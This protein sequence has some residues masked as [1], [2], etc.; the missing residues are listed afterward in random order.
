MTTIG[1]AGD[2]AAYFR[3]QLAALRPA[4]PVGP[5]DRATQTQAARRGPAP[6][7]SPGGKASAA[8]SEDLASV[9]ARRVA[10]IDRQDPDRRRK[11]FRVFLEALML[12]EWGPQLINDPGF[13][14]VVDSVHQQMEAQPGLLLLMDE[15]ARRLLEAPGVPR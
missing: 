8:G 10:A 4:Q 15:A 6:G 7:Q 11:A 13:Q 1:P 14:Q 2:L 5:A 12:D 9:L 3:G